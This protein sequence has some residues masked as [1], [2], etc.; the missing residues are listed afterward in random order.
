MHTIISPKTLDAFREMYAGTYLD[1]IQ[2]DFESAGI[3]QADV[4]EVRLPQGERRQLV[5]RY[6]S[7]LDLS[8]V[9]DVHR[10]LS[11]L[12]F[13]FFRL[14]DEGTEG[15]S[16]N[17]EW[18]NIASLLRQDGVEWNDSEHSFKIAPN[19]SR[20][21]SELSGSREAIWVPGY[22]R[23]F[24]SHV[25][26]L[27]EKTLALR[28]AL[29]KYQI[30]GFVAHADVTPTK[31]WQ[32]QIELALRSM[33]G[34]AALLSDGFSRSNWTD[35]EVG[36][37]LGKGIF[38]LPIRIAVDPYGFLAKIQALAA[39]GK[40]PSVLAYEIFSLLSRDRATAHRL[41]DCL[42]TRLEY[43]GSFRSVGEAIKL[44]ESVPRLNAEQQKRLSL[45]PQK[46]LEISKTD[47]APRRLAVLSGADS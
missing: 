41:A 43:A 8:S 44:L 23:L 25:S 3:T 16:E 14:V 1:Q 11:A 24:L 9:E 2:Q 27:K 22:F 32:Q 45:A 46:N 36:Y 30:S 4:P 17:D 21:T 10:L 15:E 33:E 37:A 26:S 6:V 29:A 39:R 5:Q 34:L 20:N 42:V 40:K 12:A 18:R 35:Q 31:E 38:V 28:K 47:G 19:G 13:Q 7:S